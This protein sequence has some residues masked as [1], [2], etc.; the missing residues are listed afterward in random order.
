MI[1]RAVYRI[2]SAHAP[3][4]QKM[5]HWKGLLNAEGSPFGPSWS[6]DQEWF[7]GVLLCRDSH[8]HTLHFGIY[9]I[10][11]LSLWRCFHTVSSRST[12]GRRL[13]QRLHLWKRSFSAFDGQI[14]AVTRVFWQVFFSTK[15]FLLLADQVADNVVSL[16]LWA[17]ISLLPWCVN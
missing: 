12:H 17:E 10:W 16:S 5:C 8:T 1:R 4:T 2:N 6:T 9:L 7:I 14:L 3:V 11:L 13:W 15:S